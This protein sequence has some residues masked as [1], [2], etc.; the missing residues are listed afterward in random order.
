M[1]NSAEAPKTVVLVHGAFADGSSYNKVI[2]LLQAEGLKTIAVQNP[3][4]SLAE[5][6]AFTRRAIEEA[7]GQVVLVGH[8]WGGAV[9]TEAGT[10]DKV[11]ALV[12][13]AAFAP[14]T[15]KHIHDVLEDAHG[16]R[17]IAT[18]PGFVN[19]TVD[20][21][22]YIRLEEETVLSYFAPDIPESDARLIAANQG[23]LHAGGLDEA[24]TEAAWRTKPSFYVV[25]TDDQMIA[26]DVER[27]MADAIGA[28]TT[29]VPASHVPM[30]SQPETVANVIIDATNT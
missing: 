17:G 1:S 19:P 26:P 16:A 12:Y 18:V 30:L 11:D 24:I 22:G 9:I 2:P 5:D 14:D 29:E 25:A 20:P 15:G 4:S 13:L 3:L 8:S 10:H 7:E 21:E 27:L 6:V 28:T 23:R